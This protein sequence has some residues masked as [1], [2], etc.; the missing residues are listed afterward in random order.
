MHVARQAGV[1]APQ[2]MVAGMLPAVEEVLPA[3]EDVRPWS[4][5]RAALRRIDGWGPLAWKEIHGAWR[6][7]AGVLVIT[8]PE[9][10]PGDDDD[11]RVLFLVVDH[12]LGAGDP[13]ATADW[14][15]RHVWGT[16][17]AKPLISVWTIRPGQ[18]VRAT[19][20]CWSTGRQLVLRLEILLPYAGMC[21][22]AKRCGRFLTR[23][24][25]F[26]DDLAVARRRPELERHR[27]SL[28]RQRA[29]RAALPAHGLCAFIGEGAILPRAADGGPF[30]GAAP[31]RVPSALRITLDLGRLGRVTGWGIPHGVTAITGA[32]YHGKSTVLQALQAGIDDH[33]PG[34]GRERVVVADSALLVQAEDGRAIK[35]QDLS[36][37]FA[38]LPG[39]DATNF[40]TQRASG[41]TSMAASVLQGVAAGC[42]LLLVDEDTAASNFLLIDPV[43]RRLLG[44]TLHGN[45]TLL[46]VLP[47]LAA[48]GVATVLV[49]GS[50]GHALAVAERVV[51][52]DHW[53]PHDVT[54]RARK[55]TGPRPAAPLRWPRPRRHLAAQPDALFGERNFAPCDLREPERPR[56]KLPT[57]RELGTREVAHWHQLD[58]RRS[59]WVLDEALVAG[60]LAAAGWCCRLA[61]QGIE[62]DTL[63]AAY[64]ALVAQGAQALD[65]FHTR[66]LA[67]PPWQLVVGVLERLPVPVISSTVAEV[68]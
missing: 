55:L 57:F 56:L 46:E 65:P 32:P 22:D 68:A 12:G 59:G 38:A 18:S 49:A 58:L 54:R 37:F 10:E 16:L 61:P 44:R 25:Q 28:V 53:Q 1:A 19:N 6:L 48:Q 45:R 14:V 43:L 36:G 4:R 42:K 67:V 60:A 2:A 8:S 52:M 17:L 23:V 9:T 40:S 41:A 35:A 31:V 20:A 39:A 3:P 63:H 24:A 51:Q 7:P 11:R 33:P 26:A 64:L 66:L 21:I 50:N 15:L 5:L 27:R 29:L 47:A 13:I 30:P 62:L 34:D